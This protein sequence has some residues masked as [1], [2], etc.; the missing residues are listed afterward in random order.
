MQK[1][2][3]NSDTTSLNSAKMCFRA[4]GELHANG[5]NTVNISS[6]SASWPIFAIVMVTGVGYFCFW[7]L[8]TMSGY[9]VSD[10]Y[11]ASGSYAGSC[12]LQV[13]ANSTVNMHQTFINGTEYNT[14]C[15]LAVYKNY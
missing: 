8:K 5:H 9:V 3:L 15:D 7:F 10:G 6:F 11:W 14:S 1:D 12:S 4:T 13:N 2:K